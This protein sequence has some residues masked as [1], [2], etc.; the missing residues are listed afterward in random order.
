MFGIIVFV[1]VGFLLLGAI[2]GTI[3]DHCPRLLKAVQYINACL[4]GS[5]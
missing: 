1:F 3:L 5:E 4:D 2:I